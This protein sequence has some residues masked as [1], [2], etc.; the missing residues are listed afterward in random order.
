MALKAGRVGVHPDQV[1][2]FGKIIP[3]NFEWVRVA[4]SPGGTARSWGTIL[5]VLAAGYDQLTP[6]EVVNSILVSGTTFDST[7]QVYIF[8]G[9]SEY[10][11]IHVDSGDLVTFVN[12]LYNKKRYTSVNG[13]KP[14]ETTASTTLASV[15]LY[16][17]KNRR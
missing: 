8:T 10:V 17:L 2:L 15:S 13:A 11:K 9:S 7:A 1:D 4:H 12:N 6:E 14:S 16:V 5:T 3:D